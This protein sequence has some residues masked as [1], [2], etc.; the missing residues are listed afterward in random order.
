MGGGLAGRSVRLAEGSG[1]GGELE[2]AVGVIQSGVGV[3]DAEGEAIGS[4]EVGGGGGVLSG[5]GTLVL[6]RAAKAST[7]ASRL[8]RTVLRTTVAAWEAVWVV[9]FD[10][11]WTGKKRDCRF[12]AGNQARMVAEFGSCWSAEPLRKRRQLMPLTFEC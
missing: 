11:L 12:S 7:D 10:G 2:L 6:N 1:G 5:A 9:A 3:A 8:R 4:V